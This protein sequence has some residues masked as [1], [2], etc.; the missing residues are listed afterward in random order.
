MNRVRLRNNR[1]VC[2]GFA[3]DLCKTKP[4]KGSVRM[5]SHTIG[6]V[7]QPRQAMFR[8]QR[9]APSYRAVRRW[10]PGGGQG[11]ANGRATGGG[12]FS[13]SDVGEAEPRS[14]VSDE[15][16]AN[17]RSSARFWAVIP[18]TAPAYRRLPGWAPAV[19]GCCCRAVLRQLPG[20]GRA[21]AC[22]LCLGQGC[23]DAVEAG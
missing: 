3:S 21:C 10:A 2:H 23:V 1:A 7:R 15:K 12:A 13:F 9:R 4:R 16:R 5:S 8:H 17:V 14:D 22:G 19:V 18:G 11:L 6:T 20:R